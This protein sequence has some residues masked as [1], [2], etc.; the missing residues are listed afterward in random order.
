MGVVL[1]AFLGRWQ[2]DHHSFPMSLKVQKDPPDFP[3]VWGNVAVHAENLYGGDSELGI[4]VHGGVARKTVP[5]DAIL[6]ID[7]KGYEMIIPLD[8]IRKMLDEREDS[9]DPA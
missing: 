9:T 1:S 2:D 4:E 3:E 6:A 7:R 8:Q 5:R